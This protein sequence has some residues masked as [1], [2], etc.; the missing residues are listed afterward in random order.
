MRLTGRLAGPVIAISLVV[1]VGISQGGQWARTALVGTAVSSVISHHPITLVRAAIPV[2]P[3]PIAQ[4]ALR[5]VSDLAATL[6]DLVSNSGAD[7]G[8]AFQELTADQP[9]AWSLNGDLSMEAAS[10]YKQPLL[11]AEA[12]GIAAH[13]ISPDD[14]IC[15]QDSDWEDGPFGDYSDGSCFARSDLMTR[16]GTY[17]DNTAAHMLVD[18]LGGDQALQDFAAAHGAVGSDLSTDYPSTTA[19][20]LAA[21]WVSEARGQI[22]GKASQDVLYPLLTN[23]I[24]E[25]GI[26]AGISGDVTV[27]HKVGIDDGIHHDSALVIAPTGDYVLVVMTDGLDDTDGWSLIAQISAAVW[28]FEAATPLS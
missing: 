6:S 13:Q 7:V 11:E 18:D 22:G 27:V 20:D 4:P 23:T 19:S 12:L 2:S 26:P 24:Y 25:A 1:V 14:Q 17:S 8:I 5:S 28:Q 15:Y 10:T 9:L 21:L 3:V 16:V